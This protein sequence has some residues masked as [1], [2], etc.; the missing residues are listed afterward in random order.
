M[1]RIQPKTEI[2]QL[3]TN[4]TKTI[5]WTSYV[6]LNKTPGPDLPLVKRTNLAVANLHLESE[7]CGNRKLRMGHRTADN[8]RRINYICSR[9]LDVD[10]LACRHRSTLPC[11]LVAKFWSPVLRRIRRALLNLPSNGLLIYFSK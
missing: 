3:A 2:E 6:T 11:S 8:R 4:K 10:R 9:L 5:L 7:L 1:Q